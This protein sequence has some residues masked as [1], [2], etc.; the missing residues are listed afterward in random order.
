MTVAKLPPPPSP[1]KTVS[2]TWFNWFKKLFN[3]VEELRVQ[4]YYSVNDVVINGTLQV[5]SATDYTKIEAD[6][7]VTFVGNATVWDDLLGAAITLQQAGP[8][9][10]RNLVENRVE[11]LATANTAD[12]LVDSQQISHSWDGT[13]INPHIHAWQTNASIPNWLVQYRWQKMG[14]IEVTAWTNLKCNTTVFTYPGS[15]VFHQL[16]TSGAGI[17]P[18]TGAGIS[19][20]LQ[21]RVIRDTTNA[22]GVFAGA[23]PVAAVASVISFDTHIA[24]NTFGSRSITTK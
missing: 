21:F 20:I 2:F 17:T 10:S 1:D 7:T 12:Y 14:A 8:G 6:G 13:N 18:P 24:K 9:I 4:G 15:G 3:K 5:G 11:Y 19:D 22:T 23:D 16:Y